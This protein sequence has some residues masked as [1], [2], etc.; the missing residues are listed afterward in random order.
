[1]NR[2]IEIIKHNWRSCIAQV[3]GMDGLPIGG[4]EGLKYRFRITNPRFQSGSREPF[5]CFF[6]KQYRYLDDDTPELLTRE[7][8]R[9]RQQGFPVPPTVRRMNIKDKQYLVMTDMTYGGRYLIWGYSDRMSFKQLQDLS[10][11]HLT[12]SD[13]ITINNLVDGLFS[14]AL[15][16]NFMVRAHYLHI[17]KDKE[18]GNIDIIVLDIN[19]VNDSESNFVTL[20]SRLNS[21][22]QQFFY[23][24]E[25]YLSSA[26]Q[27]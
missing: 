7:Y 16:N 1:M 25:R 12:Q 10:D 22:K 11:M 24:L 4:G 19:T 20:E 21:Q 5:L 26:R 18:T 17:R 27:N 2:F 14:L 3:V 9:L 15:A 6:V 23:D 13:M 8:A